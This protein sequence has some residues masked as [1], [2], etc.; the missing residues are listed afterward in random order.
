[1]SDLALVNARIVTHKEIFEGA[2]LITDGK[3]EAVARGGF[4]GLRCE[5]KDLKGKYL[6]PGLIDAH[7]HFRTPG[8]TEKEDFV[9]GSKSALAGGVTTVL[10]M[11]NNKPPVIDEA[12][13]QSK[14]EIVSRTSLCNYGFYVG[15]TPDNIDMVKDMKGVVGVKI[16]MGSSTGNLLVDKREALERFLAE[17]KGL[18]SVHAEDEECIKDGIAHFAD[19][20][21]PEVHSLIRSPECAEKAVSVLLNLAKKY[22]SR[23]H[24]AH[25][26]TKK[27]I[28]LI[29]RFK[30][31]NL[32][33]EVTP[34]HL[35]LTDKDYGMYGGLIKVNPPIRGAA[36]QAALWE[37]IADGII[38]MV[39]TDHAPHLYEE[40]ILPYEKAPSGIPG[41]QTMLPLL[42]NAVH[43]KRLS[44]NKVV[45]LTSYNP[46][47]LFR[48][49]GKG[50]IE[51]GFDADLTV[52]DMDLEKNV[53][54]DY[55]FS[56]CGWSPYVGWKLKGWPVMTLVNGGIMYEWRD[57]FGERLGREVEVG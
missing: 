25:C 12:S 33:V 39:A 19:N 8:Q 24:I 1:M 44:L 56:R 47:K 54:Q 57:G 27:E 50:E 2:V 40:K 34:H 42:L 15:A 16:Y 3:I 36:D 29:R 52:V 23:V 26:S 32:S 5:V 17:Y 6:L 11:P 20:H 13:L 9:T 48:L 43:E 49:K 10:D 35:F 21:E 18:M 31:K 4:E 30:D 7:V 41:V 46:A 37:G 55:L 45:E 22:G 28:D 51:P 38:D 53:E 14:R